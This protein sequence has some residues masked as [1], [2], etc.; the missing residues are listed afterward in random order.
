[1]SNVSCSS[2]C[3]VGQQREHRNHCG[4]GTWFNHE[5]ASIKSNDFEVSASISASVSAL[6]P[7]AMVRKWSWV[8]RNV[9]VSCMARQTHRSQATSLT[10]R[11]MM[12]HQ[13]ATHHPE[14]Q[15]AAD[16]QA[17]HD[18]NAAK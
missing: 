8:A 14:T 18:S 11:G 15:Q 10:T 12:Q 4:N 16:H 3:D 7:G 1:M 9:E 13:A 6:L 2:C 5:F 17:D